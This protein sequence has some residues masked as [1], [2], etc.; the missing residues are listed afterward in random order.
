MKRIFNIETPKHIGEEVK[1]SGWV[2]SL[3]FHGKLIFIDL[4]DKTGLVQVVIT[5]KAESYET[6]KSIRPEWVITINGKVNERPEK[7]VNDKIATGKVEISGE[8]LEVLSQAKTLPFAIDTDGK[9]IAE[10]KRLKYRYLD[11]RR[12]RMRKNLELRQE[13]T[14]LTRSF[15]KKEG[16]LEVETPIL[17][18][19]TPEGARDFIVPARLQPG[20][21]Y[22]LPQSAQQ[23]KQ[24]LMVSGIERYFQVSRCLRDEDPRGNRQAEHTQL[25]I[26]MSFVNQED[27]LDLTE[28]LITKIVEELTDKKLTFKPFLRISY[29]EAMEKYKSDKPDL[30][31]NPDDPNELAFV[32]VLDWP[33]FEW[34]EKEKRL[35]S[36]HHIF[37]SPQE[38]DIPLLET[39]PLKAHSWQHDLACNGNEVAGGS[40]RNHRP[41]IQRKI[42]E[43]VGIK[44]EEIEE[45]FGHI[46]KSFEYG[47]PPHGGIAPGLDRLIMLLCNEPNIREVMAFPKTGD[48]RDLMMDAPSSISEEQ[49][50]EV[51]LKITKK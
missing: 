8:T 10:E 30:R 6:A 1:I 38:K 20:K 27:I 50:K 12:E 29:K 35:D 45:K 17:T 48:N 26:E 46:L 11:L 42:L 25:D 47:V 15:L 4:R 23:Y 44:K 18:K 24:L 9:E 14:F 39:D 41:D 2:H 36:M 49:L 16:F 7:M 22:A 21:F 43:L 28:R 40:I 34:N 5:P 31:K 3:R 32:W 33:L 13:V 51:H 37:T 19:S